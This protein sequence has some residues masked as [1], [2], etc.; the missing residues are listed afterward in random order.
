MSTYDCNCPYFMKLDVDEKTC[1]DIESMLFIS[2]VYDIRAIDYD[3]LA[4]SNKSSLNIMPPL[5][6][7]DI[8]NLTSIDY[9]PVDKMLY[10]LDGTNGY[11]ARI[12]LNG[13]GYE[14]IIYSGLTNSV[15][16]AIDWISR[17]LYFS[18][19]DSTKARVHMSKLDGLYRTTI[20]HDPFIKSPISLVVYPTLGY[21]FLL[22]VTEEYAKLMR[23]NM[24]GSNQI[25]L[26]DSLSDHNFTKPHC[27]CFKGTRGKVN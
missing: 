1:K 7:N 21:M 6:R 13:S 8:D 12:H 17:N 14:K 23:T 27:K 22:D 2:T 11:I 24:D 19:F 18:T 25:I 26:I 10:F 16:L 9:D 15:S 4:V 3:Q 5:S 20:I